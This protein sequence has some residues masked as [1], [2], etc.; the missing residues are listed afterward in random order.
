M[1]SP[2][3]QLVLDRSGH[4][5]PVTSS[6]GR[7]TQLIHPPH[8]HMRARVCVPV[9][10]SCSRC[11]S[12]CMT[13]SYWTRT[14]IGMCTFRLA[15]MEHPN[16]LS[17]AECAHT[18]NTYMRMGHLTEAEYFLPLD[19]SDLCCYCHLLCFCCLR[20]VY[21]ERLYALDA[22]HC[23]CGLCDFHDSW[24]VCTLYWQQATR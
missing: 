12:V 9:F 20:S 22:A 11:T 19:S 6:V 3:T 13:F 18:H 24:R 10:V 15:C 16:V 7:A 23:W 8:L 5:V 14:C 21:R 4:M 1:H 17:R 2:F